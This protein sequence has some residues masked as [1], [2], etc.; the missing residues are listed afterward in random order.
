MAEKQ[1]EEK[2]RPLGTIWEIPDDLWE[3]IER[4]LA[5]LDP[6]KRTG[7]RR[8]DRRAVMNAIVFRLRSGCQWNRLPETFPDDSTV[9]RAFQDWARLG[10]FRRIWADLVKECEELGGVDWEW[11]AADGALGKARSGGILSGRIQLTER[12]MERNAAC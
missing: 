5:E 11:Q 6:P 10:V 4:I 2:K 9:H 3:K 7:R 12:R 8:V 1:D